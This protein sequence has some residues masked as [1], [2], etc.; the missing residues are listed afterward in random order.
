MRWGDPLFTVNAMELSCRRSL[1]LVAIFAVA[2]FS[3]L[4]AG[5]GGKSSPRVASVDS[6]TTVTAT[7]PQ[8][9]AVAFARCMR[10][11]GIPNWPDPTQGG[12]F[13]KTKLQRL[14]VSVS[15]VRALEEGA[16][17]HLL[18]DTGASKNITAGDRVDYLKAAA[19]MRRHGITGFPDPTF[20]N[21]SVKFNIPSSIN[22][23]SPQ[24]VSALPICR[25]LIPAGLPYSGTN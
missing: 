25:K 2:A 7:T 17:N 14:G 10:A 18:P 6:S 16:C 20:A 23:N 4:A 8:S 3:L 24:V 12:A 13:D 15:R 22:P 5:C 1:F 9:G 11:H 19:C 21:G